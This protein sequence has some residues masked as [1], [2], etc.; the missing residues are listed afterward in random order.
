MNHP[1][2]KKIVTC[3]NCR[4]SLGEGK[5]VKGTNGKWYCKVECAEECEV[6]GRMMPMG[7]RYYTYEY[8]CFCHICRNELNGWTQEKIGEKRKALWEYR[9]NNDIPLKKKELVEFYRTGRLPEKKE[10]R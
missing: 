4:D 2:N 9:N 8:E 1:I 10:N 5:A 7:S 6:C 3:A